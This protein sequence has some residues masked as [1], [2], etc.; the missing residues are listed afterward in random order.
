MNYLSASGPV[1]ESRHLFTH[2]HD[3]VEHFDVID[4]D[5]DADQ[6]TLRL[7]CFSS[8]RGGSLP[9][10][11][12]QWDLIAAQLVLQQVLV[13]LLPFDLFCLVDVG[14]VERHQVLN[15]CQ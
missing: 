11:L 12:G 13:V 5:G 6:S 14:D 15:S 4:D 7:G 1:I 10:L 3:V 2:S 9:Q 8:A